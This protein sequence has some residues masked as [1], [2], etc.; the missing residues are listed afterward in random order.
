MENEKIE[1]WNDDAQG[2]RI[3]GMLYVTSGRDGTHTAFTYDS[4]WTTARG[5]FP[6][7]PQNLP[8]GAGAFAP[9]SAIHFNGL[10]PA[11]ADTAPDRWG[12]I[13]IGKAMKGRVRHLSEVAY[14]LAL[15]DQTRIGSLRYKIPDTDAF[16]AGSEQSIPLLLTLG[17]LLAASDA[18]L[19]DE[20]MP[21]DL[22][23]LLGSGS[24]PG[25]ARPKASVILANGTL[26]FAKFPKND[27]RRSLAIGEALALHLARGCGIHAS[28]FRLERVG[29]RD[30]IVVPRFDR[31][32]ATR[33]PFISAR[34]LLGGGTDSGS[35]VE[36][37]EAVRQYGAAPA[38]D[39]PELWRRMVFGRLVRNF[40]DHLRNHAFLRMAEGWRLSPAYDI[41]PVPESDELSAFALPVFPD[42]RDSIEDA[43]GACELFSMSLG[44][45]KTTAAAM[46]EVVV[47]WRNVPFLSR[48]TKSD[49]ESAFTQEVINALDVF[50]TPLSVAPRRPSNATGRRV[51]RRT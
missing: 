16:L 43:L 25:G 45:A 10:P 21:D 48:M 46:R 14:M 13:L 39:L 17:R 15:C 32:G 40:D 42:G 12:K 33:I 4:S 22:K 8:I 38:A 37:A 6:I 49:Y 31:R 24:P 26:A 19:A 50:S 44:E 30:L 27:D 20:E 47:G 23:L 7:D 5:T 36:I 41:N 9:R 1:V 11:L 34:T 29:E 3:V 18:V 51:A 35:Y 2:L 28:P